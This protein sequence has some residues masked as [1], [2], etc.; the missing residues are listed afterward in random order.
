MD[1]LAHPRGP[2][3]TCPSLFRPAAAAEVLGDL[4][5]QQAQRMSDTTAP[6]VAWLRGEE[7]LAQFARFVLVGT[8]TTVV[9]AV[10]FIAFDRDGYM[11]AHLAATAISTALANEM[12]RRLTFRAE[13]RVGW[14]TAQVEAGGITVLGLMA[15]STALGWLDSLAGTAHVLVQIGL[16]VAVTAFIGLMRFLAL[17]WIFRPREPRTA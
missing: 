7:T 17:R 2:F 11:A 4:T 14:F 13:E 16:V 10:L 12:H 6:L 8:V 9:Y 5:R 15:T 3:V 1:L